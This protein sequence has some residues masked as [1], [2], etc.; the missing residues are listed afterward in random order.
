MTSDACPRCG[1]EPHRIARIYPGGWADRHPAA[2]VTAGLFTL[3]LMSMMLS[4]HPI[5]ALTLI[6]LGVVAWGVR[7]TSL[8]RRRREALAARADY[9]YRALAAAPVPAV[10]PLPHGQAYSLPW[11][12]VSLLSTQP[13]RRPRMRQ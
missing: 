1:Y 4:V 10:R 8:N 9:E 3:T 5:A 11:Q 7:V 12:A 13:L 2:A 6:G